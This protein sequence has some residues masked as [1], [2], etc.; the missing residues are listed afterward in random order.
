[1]KLKELRKFLETF[2]EDTEIRIG[3]IETSYLNPKAPS[4]KLRD[5]PAHESTF[6]NGE[7]IILYGDRNYKQKEFWNKH[8]VG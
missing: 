4:Y 2:H 8:S 5:Y 3:V 7:Y 6:Y 1:M